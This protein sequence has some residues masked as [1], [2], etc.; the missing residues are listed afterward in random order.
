MALGRKDWAEVESLTDRYLALSPRSTIVRL[1]SS[2]A[3]YHL[4]KMPKAESMAR[5]IENAGEMDVWPQSYIIMGAAHSNRGEFKDAAQYL[6]AYLRLN[7]NG[8]AAPETRRLLHEWKTLRVIDSDDAELSS[9]PDLS[10]P[11]LIG[12]PIPSLSNT[13]EPER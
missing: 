5:M 1:M 9:I 11:D 4:G 2:L 6:K 8:A 10:I 3:A 12:L 13:D 7:P